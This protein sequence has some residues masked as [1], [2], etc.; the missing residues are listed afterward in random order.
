[1]SLVPIVPE[2]GTILFRI[3]VL[4][5]SCET[6]IGAKPLKVP[7]GFG[8]N[9]EP[10]IRGGR[11]GSTARKGSLSWLVSPDN[12]LGIM[13]ITLTRRDVVGGGVGPG[14]QPVRDR[15]YTPRTVSSSGL[16][17][18]FLINDFMGFG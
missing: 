4:P 9:A 2:L 16:V 11:V 8:V 6:K 15:T 3:Q 5:V 1:M 7:N 14:G 13:L 17:K 10:A 18:K 12:A